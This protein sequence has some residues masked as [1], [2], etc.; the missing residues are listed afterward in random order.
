MLFVSSGIILTILFLIGVIIVLILFLKKD[1][2]DESLHSSKVSILIAARDEEDNI[3][4]CLKSISKLDYSNYEVWIGND[5]STDNTQQLIEDF[6]KDKENYHLLNV[7][8]NLGTARGK[9]NVL[10]QLSHKANGDYFFITDA[11]IEVHPNWIQKMLSSFDK[12]TGIVSGFTIAKDSGLFS[13]MQRI[14]WAYAMGMVKVVSDFGKPIVGIGNNM[15]VTKEAYFSTGGYEDLPFSIVEDYQLFTE[16]TNRG[17]GFRNLL[18][19]DVTSSSKPIDSFLEL[20]HQRKR[21]MRGAFRLP[22]TILI[23]LFLQ[24]AYYSLA[25]ILCFIKPMVGLNMIVLKVFI[26]SIFIK[27]VMNNIGHKVSFFYLILFEIYQLI[28]ST[29]SLIFYFIPVKIKWKGRSY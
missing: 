13:R 2:L 10:A 21:W 22:F 14:D 16:I 20:L 12:N 19:P 25:V 5:K 23:I 3:I 7:E 27:S 18:H 26:Q 28:L 15:A 9:A 4:D 1:E 8:S 6:I 29:S 24:A 11:D 17:Y